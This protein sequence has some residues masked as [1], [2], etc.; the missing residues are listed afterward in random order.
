M[1][2]APAISLEER[3]QW[4]GPGLWRSF[5][6][7]EINALV[8]HPDVLPGVC[9]G[10][11]APLDVTGLLAN[12]LNLFLLGAFGGCAFIWKGPG[13]FEGHSFFLPDGRGRWALDASRAMLDELFLHTQ[14]G[15]C[16][17]GWTP[18]ANRAAR[19]FNRRLGFTSDGI[20]TVPRA[21]GCQP[22]PVEA[23]SLWRFQWASKRQS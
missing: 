7:E 22:E 15:N 4:F 18:I 20:L 1:A 11:P 5:D 12:K 3:G 9:V 2:S 23:F 21:P 13:I 14:I 19:A 10:E 8:N 17:W 6:A 16:V